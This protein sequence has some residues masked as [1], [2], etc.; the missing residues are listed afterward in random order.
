M[1]RRKLVVAKEDQGLR[2]DKFLAGKLKELSRS[3]V[4][5]LIEEEQVLVN[6]SPCKANAKVTEGAILE[7]R[8]PEPQEIELA[9]EAIPL[10]IIYEDQDLLVLNKPQGLVVHPAPGNYRGTLVNALLNHCRDL[11]GIN[12]A[13]RPGIVHRLDKDTSGAMV[14]AK[15]DFAHRQLVAQLKER[16]VGRIY[17]ALVH[18]NVEEEGG[19]IDAPIG[20]HPV[21]RKKMA[22]VDGNAKPAVTEYVVKERFRGYTLIEAHLHTGRTHQIRVHLA[23]IKHPILGDPVYGPKAN[24]FGLTAQVLHAYRLTFLHPRRQVRMDFVAP[25]P[26]YF[27]NLLETLRERS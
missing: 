7:V 14:V 20:R 11:S 5:K 16:Q 27:Q 15:N 26:A 9:P 12:G 8:I 10:D 6:G 19:R 3:R 13:K 24:P 22:V 25:L 17:W 2:V 21:N 4:Q 23:Y 18:G 1:D